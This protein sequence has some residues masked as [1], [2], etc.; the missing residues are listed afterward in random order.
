MRV[1]SFT[2]ML[3]G[4]L[5][6]LVSTFM[7]ACSSMEAVLPVPKEATQLGVS[8]FDTSLSKRSIH[9]FDPVSIDQRVREMQLQQR[10]ENLYIL[11]DEREVGVDYRGVPTHI[12]AREILRRFNRTIPHVKIFGGAWRLSD[13]LI[14]KNVGPY[15]PTAVEDRLEKGG[16]L[17]SIGEMNL[18]AAISRLTEI[19]S[20][21]RGRNALLI[22][23]PWAEIDDDAVDAVRRFRQ[24]GQHA[25]G[26]G[27]IPTIDDWES[28]GGPNCVFTIGL[29]NTLSRSRFDE[30]DQCGFSSAADKIAQARDMAYFVEKVLFLAPRDSDKDGIFDYMDSCPGT[31]EGRIVDRKGCP[32]FD[33]SRGAN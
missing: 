26:F 22:I 5:L 9:L 1:L 30:V 3:R 31:S 15:I 27:V 14:S 17:D 4:S 25:L 18:A 29:G 28:S 33:N 24:Q 21:R 6:A 2:G 16:Q 12:Y 10:I 32:R 19:T 23:T 20:G 11:L 8:G 13:E 7:V